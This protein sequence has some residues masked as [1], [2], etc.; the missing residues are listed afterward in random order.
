VLNSEGPAGGAI[1]ALSLVE[2]HGGPRLKSL[3]LGFW[4]KELVH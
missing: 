4:A 2:P 3:K 1:A